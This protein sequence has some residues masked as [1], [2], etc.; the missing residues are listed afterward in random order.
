MSTCVIFCICFT[1]HLHSCKAFSN[2]D[3][4]KILTQDRKIYYGTTCKISTQF[5]IQIESY[6]WY[7]EIGQ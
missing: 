3:I 4:P 2:S 1:N 6:D 7:H 5:N